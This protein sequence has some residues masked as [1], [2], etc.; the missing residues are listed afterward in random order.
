MRHVAPV[1]HRGN[2]LPD[3]NGVFF[4]SLSDD[5]AKGTER[6]MRFCVHA[7]HIVD[8]LLDPRGVSRLWSPASDK[9]VFSDWAVALV[10]LAHIFQLIMRSYSHLVQDFLQMYLISLSLVATSHA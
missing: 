10:M 9:V 5:K 8:L 4:V 6:Q 3:P 2:F 7:L 1:S